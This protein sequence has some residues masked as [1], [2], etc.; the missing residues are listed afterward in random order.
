MVLLL[1]GPVENIPI[2][3]FD[4][5]DENMIQKAARQTK[6]AG[7]P[8]HLDSE[9]YHNM[10]LRSKYKKEGKE[11]REEI[12]KLA[13]N[14]AGTIVDPKSIEAL[15]SCRLI[16]LMNKNPGVRPIGIGEILRRLISKVI[17]W[18]IKDEIQEAAG[19]RP[20]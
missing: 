2:S 5:I 13:K 17:G 11:L 4:L 12:S 9:Q 7:G 15:T 19:L 14:I 10:L 1:N 16:P 18:V 3:Y 6:G 20:T 8:S